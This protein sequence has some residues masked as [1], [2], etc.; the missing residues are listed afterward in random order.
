MENGAKRMFNVAIAAMAI[1]AVAL[2]S[3]CGGGGGS[4]GTVG[5]GG[6]TGGG[7]VFTPP[8]VAAALAKTSTTIT[9]DGTLHLNSNNVGVAATSGVMPENSN[10]ILIPSTMS[11]GPI[12]DIEKV[13]TFLS[14]FYQVQAK[15]SSDTS[16]SV[17]LVFKTSDPDARIMVFSDKFFVNVLD[18]Q[19]ANGQISVRV[20]A[21]PSDVTANTV[22]YT[23]QGDIRYVLVKAKSAKKRAD[24]SANVFKA[25]N[26]VDPQPADCALWGNC[27][28]RT[29]KVQITWYDGLG[30]TAGDIDKAVLF[31]ENALDQYKV[32]G[33]S[34]AAINLNWDAPVIVHVTSVSGEPYYRVLMGGIVLAATDIS[35]LKGNDP[36]TGGTILH[37]LAHLL[38]GKKYFMTPAALSGYKTWWM[39][40]TADNMSFLLTPEMVNV[41]ANNYGSVENHLGGM[42]ATQYAPFQWPMAEGY[43]HSQLLRMNLCD[44][45]SIC[46]LS[47]T[48]MLT[49]LDNGAYPF[50]DSALQSKLNANIHDYSRYLLGLAPLA[51]SMATPPEYIKT[52]FTVGDYVVGYTTTSNKTLY[53]INGSAPRVSKS[54]EK[55]T[56]SSTIEQNGIYMLQVNNNGKAPGAMDEQAGN[57][58][59]DVTKNKSIPL[60]LTVDA[61]HAPV[62]YRIG[63]TSDVTYKADGAK[64]VIQPI[65]DT[66]SNTGFVRLA[67]IGL[68]PGSTFSAKVEP[69][70]LSGDWVMESAVVTSNNIVSSD[71]ES[72]VDI[73][74]FIKS[75][76][77]SIAQNGTFNP[78]ATKDQ[79]N[80][81]GTSSLDGINMTSD[82][83]VGNDKITWTF[84]MTGVP[85]P[86]KLTAKKT[87]N[88]TYDSLFPTQHSNHRLLLAGAALPVLLCITPGR[89]RRMLCLCGFVGAGL[90]GLSLTSCAG[91]KINKLDLSSSATITKIEYIGVENDTTKPLWK[92]TG[93]ATTNVDASIDVTTES[94]TGVST[95]KTTTIKGPAT[96]TFVASI[97]KDGVIV[98]SN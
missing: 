26:L 38:Q 76:T 30:L 54:A 32:K 59:D 27:R 37:E 61:G 45:S 57:R 18:I 3:G 81:A 93:T 88:L 4:G 86:A 92:M 80:F 83:L 98:K 74:A 8:A 87:A 82:A 94:D 34:S 15:G 28:K 89:R 31:F 60:A 41:N 56:I 67:A 19:P 64:F 2:F 79:Y 53:Q 40:T 10:I 63:D 85:A 46:P 5:S 72:N 65:S 66:F 12:A 55:V 96:Y 24:D 69:V 17:E 43:F 95:T 20:K 71:P 7:T 52:G 75:I 62:R 33:L 36:K 90:V 1:G 51:S 91:F 44:D 9:A 77:T 47:V 21:V 68:N 11:G 42:Y 6:T 23:G 16:G 48:G 73:A 84:N 78:N 14:D 49:A 22:S 29:G 35:G 70:D 50:S 39:E 13:Y 97:Y 25:V 58:T